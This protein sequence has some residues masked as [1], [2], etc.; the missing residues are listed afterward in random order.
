MKKFIFYNLILM[1]AV[2]CDYK[3]PSPE[4]VETSDYSKEGLSFDLP[5]YW[6]VAEDSKMEVGRY[7]E[8]ENKEPLGSGLVVLSIFDE[9]QNNTE[10]VEMMN[11]KYRRIFSEQNV[12]YE[13]L[14]QPHEVTIE[15]VKAT[16]GNGQIQMLGQKEMIRIVVFDLPNKKTVCFALTSNSDDMK[17]N[18]IFS[19]K[20]LTSMKME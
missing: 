5:K 18:K 19:E 12:Q 14:D 6:E 16:E 13:L 9:T 1:L 3:S 20:I 10:V 4:T 11:N 17:E 15:K 7:V 8:V 2:S